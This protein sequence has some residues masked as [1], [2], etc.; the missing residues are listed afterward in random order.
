MPLLL[1]EGGVIFEGYFVCLLQ[2]TLKF[3]MHHY[4]EE[5]LKFTELLSLYLAYILAFKLIFGAYFIL[6]SRELGLLIYFNFFFLI[7]KFLNLI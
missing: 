5:W 7:L 1:E 3:L 4:K 2:S 6:Q